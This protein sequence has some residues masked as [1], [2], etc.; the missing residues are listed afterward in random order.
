MF[1]GA[2]QKIVARDDG[3]GS[4]CE[5]KWDQKPSGTLTLRI[6]NGGFAYF[7]LTSN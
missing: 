1:A 7:V 3:P 5:I 2:G 6:R 4:G